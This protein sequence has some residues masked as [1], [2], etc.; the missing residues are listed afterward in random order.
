MNLALFK[1]QLDT[2]IKSSNGNDQS[3]INISAKDLYTLIQLA[4][5][6]LGLL[7]ANIKPKELPKEVSSAEHRY[8]NQII[9]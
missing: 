2:F 7:P 1:Q 4:E 6:G 8:I 9:E 5:H 3:V